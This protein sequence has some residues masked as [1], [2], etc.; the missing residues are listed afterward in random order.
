MRFTDKVGLFV[1]SGMMTAKIMQD[2][3]LSVAL[4]LLGALLA[5]RVFE[6]MR[7]KTKYRLPNVV[8]GLPFLGNIHQ[9]PSEGSC[10]YFEELAKK[11]GEM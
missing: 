6:N 2:S 9:I 3:K 10:L 5:W 1:T 8:P 4:L 11:Y 7:F